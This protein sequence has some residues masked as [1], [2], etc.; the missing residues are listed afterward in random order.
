MPSSTRTAKTYTPKSWRR[1]TRSRQ[2]RRSDI[3]QT[4]PLLSLQQTIGNQAVGRMLRA[5]FTV[6]RAGDQFE[7]E[8]DRVA[9]QV[10]NTPASV[11]APTTPLAAGTRAPTVQ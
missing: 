2:R 4:H 8:A 7:R 10:T 1:R 3:P 11:H 9:E 6:G 5:K